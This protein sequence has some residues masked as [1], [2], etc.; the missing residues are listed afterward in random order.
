MKK[1]LIA[2][3]ISLF[4]Q[5]DAS[6]NR[7][8]E[9]TYTW[10][11]GRTYEITVTTYTRDNTVAAGQCEIKIYWGDQTFEDLP[12]VNGVLGA[13]PTPYRMGEVIGSDLRM[14]KYVG[15]HTYPA[16]GSY[17][18]NV[19]DPFRNAGV[20]N[21]PQSDL[22]PFYIETELLISP[23]LGVNNSP[24]LTN[25]P[26]DDACLNKLFKHNTGAVDID[27]DSLAFRLVDCRGDDG[28]VIPT[29]YD[30]Q[31]VMDSVT[32]D[33]TNGDM[34]WDVP[35]SIGIFNF[36]IRID[37]YRQN[38]SGLWVRIGFVVRDLQVDVNNCGN[39]P[40]VIQPVG[41]FCVEAGQNLNFDVTATD[42]DGDDLVLTAFGGP[43][44]VDFP[45]DTFHDEGPTALTANF[46]WN[47]DC[48]HV[49]KQPYFVS[50][51]AVDMPPDSLGFNQQ[52]ADIYTTYITVVAPAPENPLATADNNSIQLNWDQSICQ[53]ATGYKIYRREDS[54]GF[55]PAQCETGVPDYTGYELLAT[56]TGLSSTNYLDNHDIKRG[57][58][59]CY[60]VVA[61]FDD[62]SESY[63]SEEFCAALPLSLPLLTKVDVLSTDPISGSIAVEW[64]APPILDSTNFPPPYSYKVFRADE[65]D[66][67]NFT[68]ITTLSATSFNDIGINTS[69]RGYNYRVE[70][71]S[72]TTPILVGSSEPASSVYLQLNPADES[73]QLEFVYNTP[74]KNER[75]AIFR[76]NPLTN[77]YDS[78]GESFVPNYVDRGLVNGE[79][80]CYRVKSIGRYTADPNLPAPLI[81]NSQISCGTPLDTTE[82]CAP[83]LSA[84]FSCELDSLILSWQYP[85]G[86]AC[87]PDILQYNIYYKASADLN[88]PEQPLATVSATQN[89]FMITGESVR[90]CYAITAIDD[91]GTDPGGMAH[92]SP[93]S[94]VICVESCPEIT[95]PNVF[96]PN[97]DGKNDRFLPISYKDI[98]FVEL[99]V[100]NRWG[101]LVYESSAADDILVLGWDGRDQNT[102][103]L[104][105]E[106]V[107]YYICRF[108]PAGHNVPLEQQ[109]TGFFHL[110]R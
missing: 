8:G 60:M 25:E 55:V 67:A 100:Y 105:S 32:I 4:F 47:T 7:A 35:R 23:G 69:D 71:F 6:H 3:L 56:T 24:V 5:V 18:L 73:N 79:S 30:D 80:Y 16:D 59:Y 45:A 74:W 2:T 9:I 90:G 44:E 70:L 96:T 1:V 98:G 29:T 40:P 81:N 28:I 54:F 72:G 85:S 88:F 43:F 93:L 78:I 99:A 15:R 95:F 65:V 26:I 39:N 10:V 104:C 57:A 86:P 20:Q 108:T 77:I 97:T 101:G 12:R 27:G 48:E 83:I 11:S 66:G 76:L 34:F 82:P 50:F 31:F 21:I 49:R 13:C 62:G 53:D 36:A 58:R 102:G 109:V 64:I 51:K 38:N 14:N 103:N 19:E 84:N 52:L 107:Y 42:P 89:S 33:P 63:A 17:I 75:Y 106:G 94:E 46:N 37:E 22:V 61:C 87:E 91:A 68:E 110:F 92:E 41:P